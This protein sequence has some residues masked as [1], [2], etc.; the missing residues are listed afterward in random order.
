MNDILRNY[1]NIYLES[2]SMAC[3]MNVKLQ[4][5]EM[6]CASIKSV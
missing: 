5:E 2:F 4:C 3:I 6:H 1:P